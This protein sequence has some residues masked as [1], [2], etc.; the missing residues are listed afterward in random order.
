M[1]DAEAIAAE[2][3]RLKELPEYRDYSL[4]DL[5]PVAHEFLLECQKYLDQYAGREQYKPIAVITGKGMTEEEAA[6]YVTGDS[7]PS[8]ARRTFKAFCAARAIEPIFRSGGRYRKV[9]CEC[10]KAH[11]FPAWKKCVRN[12]KLS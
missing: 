12:Q 10:W 5:I 8:R 2:V 7:N 4:D 3:H 11:D 9:D 6:S 1:I